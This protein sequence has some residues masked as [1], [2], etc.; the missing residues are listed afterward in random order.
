MN[1][2]QLFFPSQLRNRR[3]WI[4]NE[5]VGCSVRWLLG[6]FWPGTWIFWGGTKEGRSEREA[7]EGYVHVL[8]VI[9]MLVELLETDVEK[10]HK[11][12]KLLVTVTVYL[13]KKGKEKKKTK[14]KKGERRKKKKA[15]PWFL[16]W[17][18]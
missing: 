14:K 10:C 8:R 16:E 17:F 15:G 13:K 1:K 12:D 7:R 5:W 3:L 4:I 6:C 9:R 2:R 18:F 11:G